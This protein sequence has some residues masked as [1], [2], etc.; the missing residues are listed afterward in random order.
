MNRRGQWIPALLQQDGLTRALED[1]HLFATRQHATLDQQLTIMGC[2]VD[3]KLLGTLQLGYAE[4]LLEEIGN[5][6]GG[7]LEMARIALRYHWLTPN[8]V[9]QFLDAPDRA[10][11]VA[12]GRHPPDRIR[13]SPN[14][15]QQSDSK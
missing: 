3:Q 15:R 4:V 5:G 7:L 9:C 6:I 2:V 8:L 1:K 14:G 13:L 12:I 10:H 11:Q